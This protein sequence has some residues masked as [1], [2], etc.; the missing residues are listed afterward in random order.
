[1]QDERRVL[2][3]DHEDLICGVVADC[4]DDWPGTKVESARDSRDGVRRLQSAKFGLVLIDFELPGLSGLDVAQAAVNDD[5]PVLMLSGRPEIMIKLGL[6]ELP[7]LRKPFKMAELLQ[8]SQAAIATSRENVTRVRASLAQLM[9]RGE[10]LQLAMGASRRM[11]DENV[12][13]RAST[14]GRALK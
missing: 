3:V 5:V 13:Q 11:P 14:D 8:A 4:L 7:Y 9:E 10:A 12:K 1:M 2:V 6:V